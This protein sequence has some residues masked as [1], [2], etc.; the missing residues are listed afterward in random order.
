VLCFLALLFS[1][2]SFILLV[3]AGREKAKSAGPEPSAVVSG[4]YWWYLMGSVLLVLGSVVTWKYGVDEGRPILQ[5]KGWDSWWSSLLV[6]GF[7]MLFAS[8]LPPRAT[9]RFPLDAFVV[10]I[11]VHLLVLGF[12]ESIS[13][14]V[15][16]FR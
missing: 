10:L 2:L 11:G 4:V 9:G 15:E 7:L 5:G 13:K 1:S 3:I 12:V 14:L 16:R 6:G 8:Y